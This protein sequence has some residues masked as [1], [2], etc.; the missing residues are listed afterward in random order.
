MPISSLS[1]PASRLPLPATIV[2]RLAADATLTVDDAPTRS[3]S[4]VR[5]L[6][7]PPL[8]PGRP[9]TYTLTATAMRNGR[10]V[11]ATKQVTVY[12]G[13]QTEV[14]LDFPKE[15]PPPK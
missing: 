3:T 11:T 15:L 5:T 2:V 14:S 4:S 12:S 1:D 13:G 6:T 8:T 7:T 10:S 9:Y